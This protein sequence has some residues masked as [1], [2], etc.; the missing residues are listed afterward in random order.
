[1]DG[2]QFTAALF[3]TLASLAWP[4]AAV[5]IAKIVRDILNDDGPA[6]P[7]PQSKELVPRD[8]RFRS[9]HPSA[10]TYPPRT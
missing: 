5:I 4:I 9:P 10:P 8:D 1:M 7:Q 6:K 2:Y 3:T